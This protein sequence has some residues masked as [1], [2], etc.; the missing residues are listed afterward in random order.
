MKT[1]YSRYLV[2]LTIVLI[3]VWTLSCS[4]SSGRKAAIKTESVTSSM[5]ESP[6]KLIKLILPEEN[7]GFKLHDPVK[8]VLAPEDKNN[9]PDSVLVYFDGRIVRSLKSSPW[10]CIVNPEYTVKTGRKSLKVT[11]YKTG[12]ARNTIARF[13]I[14]YS[15]EVPKR[16]GYKVIN[17]YPHDRAAYTQ[18]LFYDKGLLYEGTGQENESSLR[19]AELETGKVL[20]QLNLGS[21][22]FGEGITL[23]NDRIYQVT[24]R[25]KVGFVYDKA[26][27]N[28]LHD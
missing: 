6:A 21:S 20:R 9:M 8:V 10:E 12:K 26:T 3:L 11:A 28:L 15:D 4:G 24:W 13:M 1:D 27:F 22:L 2:S 7:T 19:E 17:T 14:V 5:E 18:G 16:Y 25:S 23:Y